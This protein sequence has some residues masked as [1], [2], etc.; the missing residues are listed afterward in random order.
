[1]ILWTIQ[2][3]AAWR[4]LQEKG[5][6]R[7]RTHHVTESSWLPAYRWMKR[8]MHSRIGPAPETDCQTI[9]AWYQ[10]AGTRR[11]PDLRCQGHLP[12]GENAVRLKLE[13][14]DHRVLLSDFSLWHH[15]LNYW[16][17]PSSETDGETVESELA[18]HGLSFFRQKP[19]PHDIYH[20]AIVYTHEPD[21]TVDARRK[22][23]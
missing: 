15:V 21:Q 22:G 20:R 12:P 7:A 18:A 19:I 16:Y 10:W 14:P 2:S 5:L 3:L 8:Q 23:S 11:K 6:L 9:W 17:L 13:Y 1:M 4:E